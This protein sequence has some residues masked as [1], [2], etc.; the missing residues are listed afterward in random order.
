[1]GEGANN[2][3]SAP[4]AAEP[5]AMKMSGI[6]SEN[7]G[8]NYPGQHDAPDPAND[9]AVTPEIALND[10]SVPEGSVAVGLRAIT[11]GVSTAAADVCTAAY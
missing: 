3:A 11:S 8:A 10:S 5:S 4:T 6:V 2:P 1:L 9:H 7:Q